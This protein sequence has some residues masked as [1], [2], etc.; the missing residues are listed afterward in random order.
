MTN[1]FGSV[2]PRLLTDGVVAVCPYT[3]DDIDQLF[4]AA[5]ESRTTVYPWLPWCHPK[6]TREEAEQWV[7]Q[8]LTKNEHR[9]QMMILQASS[10]KFLG[11]V[12]LNQYNEQYNFANLGYW[13]R[14]S[15]E[16]KGYASRAARLLGKF[17]IE[18][19]GLNRVEIIASEQ[20]VAS[21]R[22]AVKSGAVHEGLLRARLPLHGAVHNVNVYS[23]AKE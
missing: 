1:A 5:R 7:E 17:G 15:A 23:F 12:G 10:G 18:E 22:V 13:V 14:T 9:Y 8:V 19:L 16:R 6:Y 2:P 11:G 20:N 21:N 3:R 4:E